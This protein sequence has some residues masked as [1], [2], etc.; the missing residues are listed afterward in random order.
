MSDLLDILQVSQ[1]LNKLVPDG[2]GKEF[3]VVD[4]IDL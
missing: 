3:G 2:I 4:L 1:N